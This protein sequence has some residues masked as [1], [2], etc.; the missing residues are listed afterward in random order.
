MGVGRGNRI[1][2][3]KEVHLTR[4]TAVLTTTT[5]SVASKDTP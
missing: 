3:G 2:G 5:Y 4:S 1:L